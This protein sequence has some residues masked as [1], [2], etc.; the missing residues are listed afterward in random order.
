MKPVQMGEVAL[1][2]AWCRR[3]AGRRG[4]DWARLIRAS[5][6]P[7]K[8]RRQTKGAAWYELLS[9]W[10]G[11]QM[12][13]MKDRQRRGYGG[14]LSRGLPPGS[15][16]CA[17]LLGLVSSFTSTRN[18]QMVHLSKSGRWG[19]NLNLDRYIHLRAAIEQIYTKQEIMKTAIYLLGHLN[20][21]CNTLYASCLPISRFICHTR[22]GMQTAM[23]YAKCRGPTWDTNI[24]WLA[25]LDDGLISRIPL[26]ED[27]PEGK[28]LRI[29]WMALGE[30]ERLS[31]QN[32]ASLNETLS[33]I[34]STKLHDISW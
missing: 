2:S 26:G 22:E 10:Q 17:I 3:W 32:E 12:M 23:S 9:S 24:D 8:H 14:S 5:Q 31:Y 18:S 25:M 28:F 15:F 16:F 33:W 29:C 21:H 13:A 20:G 30:C 6:H 1:P 27:R 19:S 4:W 11:Q 34:G 7:W